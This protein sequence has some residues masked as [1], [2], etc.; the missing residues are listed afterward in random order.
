MKDRGSYFDVRLGIFD[1]FPTGIGQ[2]TRQIG[3]GQI[4][5]NAR[6]ADLIDTYIDSVSDRQ[7]LTLER[8][9]TE[10]IRC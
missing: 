1:G 10:T 8:W 2:C 7:I 9:L 4:Q 5:W 3:I 6:V